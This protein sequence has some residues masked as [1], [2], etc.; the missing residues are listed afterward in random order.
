MLGNTS[1]NLIL[2]DPDRV[3]PRNLV[4][5]QFFP[6]DLG[7][8]K[9]QALAERLSRQYG[10]PIAYSVYPYMHDLIHKDWGGGMATQAAQ[11]L[12]VSCVD[13]AA[14]RRSI[15]EHMR[16]MNWWLDAGN[17]Y[18]SGQVLIGNADNMMSLEGCFEQKT[19]EVAALPLPSVQL[20]S[21]LI[22]VT[23]SVVEDESCADAVVAEEQSPVINQAMA[24]LVLQFVHLFLREKLTWMGAYI[25]LDA[26]T[27]QMVPADPVVVAR[28]LGV[29]VD[30]LV[31]KKSKRR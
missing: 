16:G 15:A 8:F 21:L 6:A 28:L 27:L 18:S 10:R 25:D 4:R 7:K 31:S 5:Q 29:K 13:N 19:G 30:T 14:A 26:G 17:G 2:V 20:P 12:I 24:T 3:E 11:G 9:S 23:K 22:P 1:I